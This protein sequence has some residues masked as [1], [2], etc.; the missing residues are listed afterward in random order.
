M[1]LSA[2]AAYRADYAARNREFGPHDGGWITV[3]E[4][5]QHAAR[6]DSQQRAELLGD[7]VEFAQQIVGHSEFVQRAER[8][9]PDANRT[10]SEVLL[11]LADD[12]QSVGALQL[13]AVMLDALPS[14]DESLDDVQR[15]SVAL[16]RARISWKLGDLDDAAD[17]C[18]AVARLARRT[19][20]AELHARVAMA[21]CII[22]QLRGNLPEMERQARRASRIAARHDF[23]RLLRDA[24]NI[25]MIVAGMRLELDEAL[26]YGWRVYEA[27]SGEPMAEAETLQNV[28]Q[29]LLDAG[30]P[31]EAIA[32]FSSVVARELPARFI[33]PALGG[34]A[35]AGAVTGQRDLV[36]WAASEVERVGDL[37]APRWS[38]GMALVEC[39]A[40]LSIIQPGSRAEALRV[41]AMEIAA[42][43]GF[44]EMAFRA[45]ALTSPSPAVAAPV[46][47]FGRRAAGVARK[48]AWLEPERLPKHVLV[49]ASS[50]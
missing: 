20:S 3:A 44:H 50:V 29:V 15:G 13:A 30:H 12:V 23:T 8:E 48:V 5:L 16:H 1:S 18:R 43:H 35:V 22:A 46:H 47:A 38:V 19:R 33:L 4:L 39:A 10:P 34:L 45:E 40:A 7:A 25:L 31:Q 17:R 41:R 9:W 27:S 28:G 49:A 2:A 6:L 42:A 36:E 11:L 32:A 24:H 14:A 37:A 26:T 21:R